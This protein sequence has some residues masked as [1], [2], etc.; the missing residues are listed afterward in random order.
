M[1][2]ARVIAVFCAMGRLSIRFFAYWHVP[3]EI[4]VCCVEVDAELPWFCCSGD[5]GNVRVLAIRDF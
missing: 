2:R 5:N 1:S 3:R 4:Y